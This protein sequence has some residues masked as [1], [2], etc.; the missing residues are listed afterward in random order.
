MNTSSRNWARFYRVGAVVTA[1]ALAAALAGCSGSGGS[2]GNSAQIGLAAAWTGNAAFLGPAL[3]KGE[4]VA[5]SNINAAGGVDGNKVKMVTADTAGTAQGATSAVDKLLKADRVNGLVGPTSV[6][7]MSV[8]D[9]IQASQV[10]SM[11]LGST[12]ALDDTIKGQTTFRVTPSDTLMGPA[13]AQLAMSKGFDHCSI[14]TEALEG[15]Q[16]IHDNV[17]QAYKALGGTID[18]DIKIAVK[19][20][21]YS[22]EVLKLLGSPTPKCVFIEISP[23]SGAQ[24]WQNASQSND[25]STPLFIGTDTLL[26]SDTLKTLKPVAGQANI[27]A[28]SPAS[29]G[30]GRDTY[31]KLYKKVFPDEDGPENLSDLA[32]DST[33]ILA[34]AMQ[35]AKSTDPSKY[36]SHI[37]S[38]ANDGARCLSYA[39][40][41]KLLDQGKN[42]DFD[43]ASGADDI[44]P[45]GNS[46]SGF[47]VF[48]IK[49]DKQSQVGTISQADVTQL[50]QKVGM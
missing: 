49:G 10:P 17:V 27:V 45:D 28:V 33:V 7:V 14:L 20:P 34:L 37:R 40:C 30:A 29:V 46:I 6:T 31:V 2:S 13:M 4:K 22:S 38:V 42:I 32:Y 47:G 24:F 23:E 36:V 12:A 3:E 1:G 11:I 35:E 44:Q 25:V 41:K 8:L 48:Q 18:R 19:Q 39:A 50:V 16:S 43:G 15:A 9:R 21:S 5:I 26:N